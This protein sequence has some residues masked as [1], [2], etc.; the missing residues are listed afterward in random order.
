MVTTT[1]GHR[2][3]SIEQLREMIPAPDPTAFSILKQKEALDEH[4]RS[5]IAA[6]PFM[7]LA[8]A[9]PDGRCDVSPRGDAPGFVMVLDERTIVIPDRP[10]NRRLDSL[11]NI[12]NNPYAGTLFMVP[13][14][15]ET[16][17][18]NGRAWLTDDPDLLSQMTMQ[19]RQPLLGI[20][21]EAEE[22]YFQCARAFKRSK[23]W[24]S[25]TWIDRS[26]LP[27]FAKILHDQIKPD[28]M[29]VETLETYNEASNRRLYS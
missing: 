5:V 26:A 29:S 24:Q 3:A 21:I 6:A 19:N 18:I 11:E 22:V 20:V 4:C 7:L 10:G 16:L 13:N 23:L 2:I 28:G 27:S 15:D 8:T 9:G 12:L 25:D 1:T 14:M 17:R